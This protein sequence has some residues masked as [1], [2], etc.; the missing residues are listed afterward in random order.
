MVAVKPMSGIST[1]TSLIP[2]MAPTRPKL[3]QN[4]DAVERMLVGNNSEYQAPNP[5][6]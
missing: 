3:K 4:P 2:A 1:G 5:L 6:K